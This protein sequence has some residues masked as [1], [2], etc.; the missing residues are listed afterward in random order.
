LKKKTIESK[1]GSTPVAPAGGRVLTSAGR[2]PSGAGASVKL[3]WKG[4][5]GFPERSRA[6]IVPATVTL[7]PPSPGC[8][9]LRVMAVLSKLRVMVPGRGTPS[10]KRLKA[11]PVTVRESRDSLMKSVG[12]LAVGTLALPSGGSTL[13][14]KGRSVSAAP[15]AYV[16]RDTVA[17]RALPARSRTPLSLTR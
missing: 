17:P 15:A 16:K 4:M 5:S 6:A 14:T 13:R 12:S 7:T 9:P 2:S 8:S 1:L 10:T 11:W 3:D